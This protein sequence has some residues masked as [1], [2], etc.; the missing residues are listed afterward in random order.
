MENLELNKIYHGDCLDL[1]H[2]IPDKSIDMIFADLPFLTTNASWDCE[3]SLPELWKHYERIIKDNGAILLN[4]Q[5][6]FDKILGCS[7]LPLLRYEWIWEKTHATGHYNA[8]LM[9]M[10]A[11]ENILVFYK[12]LPTYNPQM[13]EGHKPSNTFTK[14]I[15]VQNKSTIYNNATREIKGGGKTTRY[16]RSVQI[17]ASDKQKSNLHECQ[18]PISLC[19]YFIKTY[20]NEG[21]VILDN[22]CGSGTTVFSARSLNRSF[23]MMKV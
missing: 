14:K 6:P 8:K 10:K 12:K 17:F 23:I 19:D 5:S 11:H 9:P 16:P 4:A 3:I 1:M 15:E 22:S 2:G 13:T 20:S 21:D 18:K 7:N